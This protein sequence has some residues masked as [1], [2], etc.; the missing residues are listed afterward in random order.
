[1]ADAPFTE[2][3]PIPAGAEISI[4]EASLR[5]EASPEIGENKA[6]PP[7]EAVPLRVI[8]V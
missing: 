7:A 2:Q 3:T 5:V 1:M 8:S 4:G 6:T